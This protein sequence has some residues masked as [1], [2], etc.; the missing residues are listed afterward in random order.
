M[1]AVA[2][3]VNQSPITDPGEMAWHLA[4][5]P[6]D[7]AALQRAARG[8]V[9]HYRADNPLAHASPRTGWQRSTVA[10]PR[11]CSTAWSSSTGDR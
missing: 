10:T 7:L 3:Y 8:L 11:R 9:L 6:H 1:E 2:Y 4:E 5:L